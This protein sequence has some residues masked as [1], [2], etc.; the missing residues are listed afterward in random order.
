MNEQVIEKLKEIAESDSVFDSIHEDGYFCVNDYAGGNM[1]DAFSLGLEE[2]EIELARKLLDMM[3][4][5][6]IIP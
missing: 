2:G 6:Y 5:E 3:N 4:V 1:D